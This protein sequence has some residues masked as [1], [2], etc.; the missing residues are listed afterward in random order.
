MRT[1]PGNLTK[2]S[3]Q[4]EKKHSLEWDNEATQMHTP[5][6]E[7]NASQRQTIYTW[8]C[9]QN[10]DKSSELSKETRNFGLY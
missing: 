5:D 9:K 1:Q 3:E 10:Y 2:V 4:A 6:T 7:T 8:R